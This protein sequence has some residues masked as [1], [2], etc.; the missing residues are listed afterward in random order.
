MELGGL[1]DELKCQ[2]DI[3]F[4][5]SHIHAKI[6]HWTVNEVSI[7]PSHKS[8]ESSLRLTQASQKRVTSLKIVTGG[9]AISS[10]VRV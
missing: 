1:F 5:Y 6:S 3:I 10:H 7:C 2:C 9:V 4:T 8:P